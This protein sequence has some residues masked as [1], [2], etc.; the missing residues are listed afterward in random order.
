M[1]TQV[2]HMYGLSCPNSEM[3]SFKLVSLLVSIVCIGG[4]VIPGWG[5]DCIHGTWIPSN[6]LSNYGFCRC[7]QGWVGPPGHGEYCVYGQENTLTF[8]VL[9]RTCGHRCPWTP[10]DP[11]PHCASFKTLNLSCDVFS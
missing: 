10:T 11:N 1:H 8:L 6:K 3:K 2:V 4:M 7:D 5:L 9:N